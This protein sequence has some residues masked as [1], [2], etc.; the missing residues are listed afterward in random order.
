MEKSYN[1]IDFITDANKQTALEIINTARKIDMTDD[2]IELVARRFGFRPEIIREWYE[3][4][5]E[6]TVHV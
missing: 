5:S 2:A 3:K 6:D 1:A 4:I